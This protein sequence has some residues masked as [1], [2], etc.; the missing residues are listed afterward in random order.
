MFKPQY[1]PMILAGTKTTTIRQARMNV[2]EVR[3][4]RVWTGAAYR[5][6]QREFVR[7]EIVSAVPFQLTSGEPGQCTMSMCYMA[8]DEQGMTNIARNDGFPG[9]RHLLDAFTAMHGHGEVLR[10]D[11]W[12]HRFV[13]I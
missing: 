12:L 9:W 6:K 4:F 13:R 5:S 3:S 2:G 11:G 7:A 10:F 1:E 8:C